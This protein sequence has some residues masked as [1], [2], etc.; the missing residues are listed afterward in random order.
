[1]TIQQ[2]YKR[3]QEA[4]KRFDG[5][6]SW[7]E[8]LAFSSKFR[9]YSMNNTA[10]IYA[11][12]PHATFLKGYRAWTELGRH[13]KRGEKGIKIFA[14]LMKKEKDKSGK[15]K[16]S[17]KGFRLISVFDLSQTEG[18]DTKL[19]LVLKGLSNNRDY[20]A[21]FEGIVANLDIP[22]SI[23]EM[24]YGQHG[25]YEIRKNAIA[26]S[27]N[28]SSLHALKTLIHEMA[29]HYRIKLLQGK[30]QRLSMK[31]EEFIA[32]SSAYLVCARL[33]IDTGDYSIPYIK[34]WMDDMKAFQ[35]LRR[36]IETTVKKIE[37]LIPQEKR[38]EVA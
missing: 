9:S 15:E 33:G 24:D 6:T 3:L 29:H 36:A 37:N 35:E 28:N 2:A 19:P 22:V 13:V 21:L 31:Q 34:G 10:L 5:E 17:L 18:D 14:P 38:R 1:M 16:R 32:E 30:R 20:S 27:K 26:I 25:Y 12:K 23:E 4:Y 8:Y 7:K 11:Q